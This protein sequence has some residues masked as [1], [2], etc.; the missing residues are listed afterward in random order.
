MAETHH[1][2]V[3]KGMGKNGFSLHAVLIFIAKFQTV[4]TR[5]FFSAIRVAETK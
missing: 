3:E 1:C 2:V 5:R 4:S